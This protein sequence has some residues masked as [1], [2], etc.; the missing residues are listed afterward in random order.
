MVNL[1]DLGIWVGQ[2]RKIDLAAVREI[3]KYFHAVVADRR[4]LD[5]LALESLFRILQLDQLA[6]AVRS[7]VG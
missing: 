7:P 2:Q 6:F 3:L 1:D 4:Q 5:T